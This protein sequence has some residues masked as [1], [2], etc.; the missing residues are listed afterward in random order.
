M[1]TALTTSSGLEPIPGTLTR[2]NCAHLLMNL[3]RKGCSGTLH[4]PATSATDFNHCQDRPGLGGQQKAPQP[5][6]NVRALVLFCK[7]PHL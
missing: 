3:P 1:G 5:V 7:R 6:L 4:S 2:A